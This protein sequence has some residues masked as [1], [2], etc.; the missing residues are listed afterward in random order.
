MR[1]KGCIAPMLDGL[2]H[3]TKV[4]SLRDMTWH[5]RLSL[6][7]YLAVWLSCRLGRRPPRKR[8]RRCAR[9]KKKGGGGGWRAFCHVRAQRLQLNAGSGRVPF[10]ALANE[11]RALPEDDKAV[12]RRMGKTAARLHR[13]GQ[14]SF[15]M[16]YRR[17]MREAKHRSTPSLL[18]AEMAQQGIGEPLS[19]EQLQHIN[20]GQET[21]QT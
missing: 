8:R 15:P 16:T 6:Q 18:F 2:A 11:Y 19:V 17:A 10:R 14:P 1:C 4:M 3:E 13:Q 7:V 5:C 9:E 21:N 12:Y 20:S